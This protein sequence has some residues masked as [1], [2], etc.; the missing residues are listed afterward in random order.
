MKMEGCHIFDRITFPANPKEL[1]CHGPQAI[2]GSNNY[3]GAF[4]PQK[5]FVTIYGVAWP[6]TLMVIWHCMQHAPADDQS[7]EKYAEI[8]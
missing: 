6:L 1:C 4:L 7:L 2:A 8:A 5:A 3:A